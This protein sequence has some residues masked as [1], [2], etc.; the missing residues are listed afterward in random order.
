MAHAPYPY[1]LSGNLNGTAP[2]NSIGAEG[3]Y[4]FDESNGNIWG[5]KT[6]NVW[7]APPTSPAYPG[8]GGTP[9]GSNGQIQYNNS[10]AFGGIAGTGVNGTTA[11]LISTNSVDAGN[12]ADGAWA[13]QANNFSAGNSV[14]YTYR[15]QNVITALPG[16]WAGASFY[17]TTNLNITNATYAGSY[18]ISTW[19]NPT[20]LSTDTQTG[21][22]YMIGGQVSNHSAALGDLEGLSFSAVNYGGGATGLVMAASSNLLHNDTGS[23]TNAAVAIGFDT[24]IRNYESTANFA[25]FYGIRSRMSPN[26]SATYTDYA[27]L[28]LESSAELGDIIRATDYA[29]TKEYFAVDKVGN[30]R[31]F[32]GAGLGSGAGV[33]SAKNATTPPTTDPTGGALLWAEGGVWNVRQSDGTAFP[34]KDARKKLAANTTY[35]VATT[36]NDSNPGTVGSPFLT[37]AKAVSTLY[38]ID[39]N[40]YGVTIQVA[41]GTY[42]ERVQFLNFPVGY[43]GS[44]YI[45]LYG[46]TATPTNVVIKGIKTNLDVK[47]EAGGFSF[48]DYGDSFIT[49][50]GS[51]RIFITYPMN[52]PA[53]TGFSHFDVEDGA[54]CNVGANFTVTGGS[55]ALFYTA[56]NANLQMYSG[57]TIT[58]TGTPDFSSGAVLYADVGSSMFIDGSNTFSGATTGPAA[59]VALLSSITNQAAG[60]IGNSAATVAQK[61]YTTSGGQTV[62]VDTGFY[63]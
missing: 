18:Y 61:T 22:C 31:L 6:N 59:N 20:V 43:G 25:S 36:G 17:D 27:N 46:N 53:N 62:T 23:V 48:V 40:N 50:Y 19:L 45:R 41:D 57:A 42:P 34:I 38:Q 11:N 55:F 54:I 3:N 63:N 33:V 16:T 10:G 15:A 58:F 28:L 56:N 37:I 44:S 21:G 12:T 7:P 39:M 2:A 24:W 49:A 1:M 14:R 4:F 29:H 52:Y 9:G 26:A 60:T 13:E 51:S 8:G 30:L 35:Y 32:G 5:P 47:I